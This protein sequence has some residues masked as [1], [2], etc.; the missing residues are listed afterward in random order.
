[1]VLGLA[2]RLEMTGAVR[3]G[4]VGAVLQATMANI[5]SPKTGLFFMPKKLPIGC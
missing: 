5:N 3:L 1:M 4:W 2:V